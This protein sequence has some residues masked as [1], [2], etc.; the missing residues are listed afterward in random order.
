MA[1][2]PIVLKNADLELGTAAA[3]TDYGLQLTSITAT[4][5]VAVERIKTVKPEGRFASVDEPEWSLDL[6]Y[7]YGYDDAAAE[8][9]AFTE[10]LMNH[11][12]EI[13]DFTFRPLH[14]VA[15]S[16]EY[17]GQCRLVA[18]PLGGDQGAFSTQTVSLP[19]E[20]QIAV[21]TIAVIP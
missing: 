1:F 8:D 17:T 13:V 6:G 14:A 16:P 5:D 21:G 10:Y 12:G 15:G 7:L 3:G 4:P 9:A 11:N 20:G 2:Q 18:G 19:V